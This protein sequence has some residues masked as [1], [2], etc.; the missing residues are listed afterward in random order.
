MNKTV[1]ITGATS[2]IGLACA[3]IFAANHFNLIITGR[4]NA[5]LQDIKKNLE[6]KFRVGVTALCF[7][8]QEKEAVFKAIQSI[9]NTHPH[10]DILINNAGLALGREAFD[11]A[12]IA[13]W[14]TMINTNVM[15]LLYVSSALM[16]AIKKKQGQ[17]VNIGTVAGKEVYVNGNVDCASKFAENGIEH[18]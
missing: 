11:E 6:K 12:D 14:E 5:L 4:R 2:G 1:F 15:G 16:P 18:G 3:E 10:I 7:D 17:I 13:D 9:E 8:V